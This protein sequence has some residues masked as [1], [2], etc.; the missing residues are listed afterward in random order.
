MFPFQE[1][2]INTAIREIN[3][4]AFSIEPHCLCLWLRTGESFKFRFFTI[5]EVVVFTQL[6][7]KLLQNFAVKSIAAKQNVYNISET[8]VACYVRVQDGLPQSKREMGI[9]ELVMTES[10]YIS[11][12]Q[13][14]REV[15][16]SFVCCK[17]A[18]FHHISCFIKTFLLRSINVGCW[19]LSSVSLAVLLWCQI[20]SR[21]SLLVL[22]CGGQ[23]ES[24]RLSKSICGEHLSL[25][26]VIEL[27]VTGC[28]AMLPNN[29]CDCFRQK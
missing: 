17:C 4:L 16:L 22:V 27:T 2:V 28:L 13:M 25:L 5:L 9:R 23:M 21:L 1:N 11:A 29:E 15:C 26:P 19:V 8:L 7:I 14:I 10:N 6:S 24:C 18:H 12:I 3:V 20:Y